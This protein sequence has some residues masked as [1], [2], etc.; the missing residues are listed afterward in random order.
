MDA[1]YL[2]GLRTAAGSAV[3]TELF[4][5]PR[6]KNLVV[7]GA[8]LQAELHI[9]ALLEVRSSLEKVFRAGVILWR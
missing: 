5:K 1:T 8:G 7:F 6:P 2:T 4:A 9:R 3:A